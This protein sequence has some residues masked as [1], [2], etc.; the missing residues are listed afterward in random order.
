MYISESQTHTLV[1]QKPNSR[2][3]MRIYVP[4]VSESE[5]FDVD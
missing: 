4:Y 2:V 5:K 1:Y 3:N